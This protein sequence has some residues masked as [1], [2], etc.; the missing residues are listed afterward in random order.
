[1]PFDGTAEEEGYSW[2][3]TISH[4]K[5]W[6]FSCHLINLLAVFFGFLLWEQ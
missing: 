4:W 6:N 2:T 5:R 1:M 3:H